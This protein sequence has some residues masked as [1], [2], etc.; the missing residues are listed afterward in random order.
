VWSASEG[1]DIEVSHTPYG[2][3]I[4]NGRAEID[5]T[6]AEQVR[7]LFDAYLSG[8]ALIP[9]AKS[10]G[11]EL[12]HSSVKHILLN[13]RYLGDEFYPQIISEEVFKKIPEELEKR[14]GRLGRT[15]GPK[16]YD[17][18]E[19]PTVFRLGSTERKYEDPFEQAAFIYSQIEEV[20]DGA[21][22][23]HH[24]DSCTE[25]DGETVSIG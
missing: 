2:Y 7:K 5:E 11:L 22:E 23:K 21:D 25:E 13:R 8:M 19:V 6:Q 3:R 12:T 17:A 4:E 14:A 1:G 9:A 15:G 10:A 18:P 24:G 16:K 20:K